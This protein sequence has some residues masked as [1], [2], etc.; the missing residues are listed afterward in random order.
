[1]VRIAPDAREHIF[2]PFVRLDPSRDRSTGD[3]V[4]D[5]RL[6]AP[7]PG[8]WAERSSVKKANQVVRNFVLAGKCYL[9]Q[10]EIIRIAGQI[11][12]SM[13]NSARK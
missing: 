2:D 6:Y 7:L 4:W 1:M 5:W 9:Y 8:Q 11:I 13:L 12:Y 10:P 3:V